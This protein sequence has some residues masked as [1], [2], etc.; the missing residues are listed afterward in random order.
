MAAAH[1]HRAR[2]TT[3]PT[4]SRQ[5]VLVLWGYGLKRFDSLRAQY[6]L[7]PRDKG[8][9]KLMLS[10]TVKF[11]AQKNNK[12]L[13]TLNIEVEDNADYA[14]SVYERCD[15]IAEEIERDL[16]CGNVYYTF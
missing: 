2:L 1:S 7:A 13:N 12:L 4:G 9:D 3:N 14:A 16:K 8:K 11:Y 5:T 15:R 6:F 10:L